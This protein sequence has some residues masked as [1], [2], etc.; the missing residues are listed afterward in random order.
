MCI[1]WVRGVIR[2]GVLFHVD[3][4]T[5]TLFIILTVMTETS[6]CAMKFIRVLKYFLTVF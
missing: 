4:K 6:K 1:S 2:G 3:F 5:Y